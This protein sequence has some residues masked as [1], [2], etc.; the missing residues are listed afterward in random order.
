MVGVHGSSNVDSTWLNRVKSTQTQEL[1]SQ[2]HLCVNID[3]SPGKEQNAAD[4]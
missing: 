3:F 1:F 2:T 4:W